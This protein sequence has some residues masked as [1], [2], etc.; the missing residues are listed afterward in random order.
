M[1]KP[2]TPRLPVAP[3]PAVQECAPE[4]HPCTAADPYRQQLID[5]ERLTLMHTRIYDHWRPRVGAPTA[6]ALAR[7]AWSDNATYQCLKQEARV[8]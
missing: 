6:Y 2:A 1:R 3:P 4:A 7:V 8:S 5:D